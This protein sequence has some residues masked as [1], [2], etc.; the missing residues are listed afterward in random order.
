MNNKAASPVYLSINTDANA[1]LS[2][3]L[4]LIIKIFT[5]SPPMIPGKTLLKN[6]PMR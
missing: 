5:T 6:A 4:S 1:C 2:P 3:V